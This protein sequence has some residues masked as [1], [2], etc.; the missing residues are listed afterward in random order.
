[1]PIRLKKLIGTLLLVGFVAVYA[2][3]ATAYA[4]LYLAESAAY[5]H[6]LYF[7]ATGIL[8]VVPAMF[9]IKWM[10]GARRS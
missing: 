10:E 1:M 3:V 7:F 8:W 5:V 4:T 6:L 2:I 9:V